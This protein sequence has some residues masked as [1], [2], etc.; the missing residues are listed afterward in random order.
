MIYETNIQEI[1]S[2]DAYYKNCIF[3]NNNFI[4]PYINLGISKHPINQS[5]NLIFIKKAFMVFE[6]ILFLKINEKEVL[7]AI[8]NSLETYY[9]GGINL[10]TTS[11]YGDMT[12]QSEKAYLFSD[13]DIVTSEKMWIPVSLHN[14]K[15]NID[16]KELKTH[17]NP[18]CFPTQLKELLYPM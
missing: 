6:N 2:F 12:I 9:F 3:K 16:L 18:V 8:P 14:L 4:I 5:Q 15:Q 13:T 7:K 11:S 1:D 10:D 17:F